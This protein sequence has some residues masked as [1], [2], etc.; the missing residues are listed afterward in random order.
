M[1]FNKDLANQAKEIHDANTK[2]IGKQRMRTKKQITE[3]SELVGNGFD[4]TAIVMGEKVDIVLDLLKKTFATDADLLA[5]NNNLM[6]RIEQLEEK[7]LNALTTHNTNVEKIITDQT[8]EA[9]I[10]KT[11][12]TAQVDHIRAAMADVVFGGNLGDGQV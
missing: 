4:A 7:L 11:Q 6:K 12:V 3:L 2:H 10:L 1:I 9:K 8:L 5:V